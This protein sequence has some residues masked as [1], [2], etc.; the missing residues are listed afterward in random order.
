ML[1]VAVVVYMLSPMMVQRQAVVVLGVVAL[2]DA[3][4][5]SVEWRVAVLPHAGSA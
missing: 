3:G 1:V 4:Y 2:V 5:K